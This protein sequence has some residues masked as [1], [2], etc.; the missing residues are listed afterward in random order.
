V[1][2]LLL[3]TWGL[4]ILGDCGCGLVAGSPVRGGGIIGNCGSGLVAAVRPL[5]V[6]GNPGRL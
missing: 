2:W 4:G 5:R 3:T 6:R 1:A